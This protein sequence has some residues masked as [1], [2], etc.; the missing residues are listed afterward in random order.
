MKKFL[1]ARNK[2][3]NKGLFLFNGNEIPFVVGYIYD[4]NGIGNE[5]ETWSTGTY[6]GTLADG[7]EALKE[8]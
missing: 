6:Y 4:D 7:M 3:G 2:K 8:D 5:V 1:L